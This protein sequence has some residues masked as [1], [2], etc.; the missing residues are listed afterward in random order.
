MRRQLVFNAP[1]LK[2]RRKQLRNRA[3]E[4]ERILWS[5]LKKNIL[6]QKFIRQYSVQGYVVDFYCPAVRLA[7]ELDGEQHKS[8]VEYD[9]YRTKLLKAWGINLIRFWNWEVKS[10]LTQVLHKI[11]LALTKE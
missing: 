11:E 2:N 9:S 7:I 10:G 3:T 6:K 8:S 1:P 4:A 5:C